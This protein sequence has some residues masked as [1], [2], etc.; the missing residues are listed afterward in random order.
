MYLVGQRDPEVVRTM[1]DVITCLEDRGFEKVH[2]SILFTWQPLESPT[3]T[4]A[5]RDQ[6]D[7]DAKDL[8]A[9]IEEPSKDCAKEHGLF[10]AQEAAWA[11]ELRRLDKEEPALVANLIREGLLEELEKPGISPHISGD[12]PDF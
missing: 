1:K 12:D 2:P 4:K 6:L 10:E 8:Q 5:R 7:Q 11:A 3:E 9:R